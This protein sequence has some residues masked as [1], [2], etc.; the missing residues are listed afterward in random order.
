[1]LK[2]L[3]VKTNQTF[4]VIPAATCSSLASAQNSRKTFADQ[5]CAQQKPPGMEKQ[6]PREAPDCS[7]FNGHLRL[8][9]KVSQSR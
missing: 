8:V 1:M 9:T 5:V 2:D 4:S 3:T 6:S 7:C